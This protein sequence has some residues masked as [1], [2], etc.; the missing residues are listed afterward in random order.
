MI[1]KEDFKIVFE[2]WEWIVEAQTEGLS[3]EDLLFQPKPGGN[4]ML[5]V[6]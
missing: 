5:W 4:C 3:Y 1:T 6:V 2:N